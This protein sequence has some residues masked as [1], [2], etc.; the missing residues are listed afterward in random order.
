MTQKENNIPISGNIF[1][2]GN[3]K[4]IF[5]YKGKCKENHYTYRIDELHLKLKVGYN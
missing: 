3:N 2:S 4:S 1:L 5:W